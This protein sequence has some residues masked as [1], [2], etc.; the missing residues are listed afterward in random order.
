MELSNQQHLFSIPKDVTY[1]NIASLS[2]SFK[3]IEEA[4]I[5][6]ILDKSTPHV[7]PVSDFFD[8]VIEL[9]KLFARLINVDDSNR[10]ATIPSVSYGMACV[11]NNIT[12]KPSDE[13]IIVDEQFPSNYYIWKKLAD[14][15][16]ASLKFVSQPDT[17]TNRGQKWNQRILETI[18]EN[19]ALVA[20]GNVH[21]SNGT[22]FDLKSIREKTTQ[23]NSLLVIDGS[24]SVG[25]FPFSVKEIQ[26][27]ALIC[28]G[29]KWLFGPYGCAYAYFGSYFDNGTPIEENWANRLHSE[30]FAGLTQYQSE[31]KP[32][33]N[34]Y[35]VGES[36]SFIYVK[37]QIAALKQIIE[38]SPQSIQA[39]YK[40]ITKSL[41]NEL[42]TLGCFIENDEDRTHH[43][44][45][46][47]LPEKIDIDL[48]KKTLKE[49]NIYISFRGTYLRL[50]CHLYN[51]EKDFETLLEIIKSC[52]KS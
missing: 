12:L 10:I 39:Y 2:P 38:W 48:L 52:I 45:G 27:D 14:K 40:K 29:Y 23:Y 32:L 20:M 11:A 3:S 24:Q 47:G 15:Y 9:K 5:Q 51:S 4:G 13:I 46:V 16:G 37:M 50:S 6:A 22:L 19:T 30:N 1:L 26:P 34:R 28:A 31:Y 18:N 36:G 41:T 8:P 35:M 33:A 43:M 7:I 49:K 21:W 42:R 25:A 17:D 44:F